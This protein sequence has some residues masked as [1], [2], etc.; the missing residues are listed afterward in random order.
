MSCSPMHCTVCRRHSNA[1]CISSISNTHRAYSRVCSNM[2]A[3]MSSSSYSARPRS[4]SSLARVYSVNRQRALFLNAVSEAG[5]A[6]SGNPRSWYSSVSGEFIDS[7]HSRNNS[8]PFPR[9]HLSQGLLEYRR[10]HI[11]SCC[12]VSTCRER[13]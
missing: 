12:F 5:R 2:A 10:G 13:L 9:Y 4:G 6:H 1:L 3:G 7:L 11:H 8:S